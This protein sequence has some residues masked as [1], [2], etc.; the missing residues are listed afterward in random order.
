VDTL[1]EI[2]QNVVLMDRALT[3]DSRTFLVALAAQEWDVQRHNRGATI[4]GWEDLVRSV[5]IFTVG[6]K[7]VAASDR[8][9]V[10]RF[11][12]KLLFLVVTRSAVHRLKLF[13]VGELLPFQVLVTGNA[14]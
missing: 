12:M 10:E 11:Q 2:L 6:G 8:L 9:T 5:A 1:G 13:R 14:R 4:S 7:R 3:G